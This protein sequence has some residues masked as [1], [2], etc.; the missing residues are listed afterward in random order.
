VISDVTTL[1]NCALAIRQQRRDEI[2]A[3]TSGS[4]LS[5]GYS[6]HLDA[7]QAAAAAGSHSRQLL[8][9]S[10]RVL[11]FFNRRWVGAKELKAPTYETTLPNRGRPNV[12]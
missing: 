4:Y 10:A 5:Y 7:P 12:L 11:L 1:A 3:T 9:K 8:S 2:D 6:D